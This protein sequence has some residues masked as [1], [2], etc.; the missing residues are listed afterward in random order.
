NPHVPA[1]L[2]A[3]CERCLE[4]E[5][6]R[7]YA[8]AGALADDLERRWAQITQTRRFARLT[9][10]AGLVIVARQLVQIGPFD[11]LR[12]DARLLARWAGGRGGGN[13]ASP[14]GGGAGPAG[15]G[16]RL[17]IDSMPGR[18]GTRR[19]AGAMGLAL[20]PAPTAQPALDSGR[21]DRAGGMDCAGSA[22]PG[23]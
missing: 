20:E 12:V 17:R 7:R 21:R 1:A 5:P 22:V 15:L 4:K 19:L 8:E 2:D 23:G 9:A 14:G 6:Q 13:P 3:L 16:H 11:R 10:T 18:G